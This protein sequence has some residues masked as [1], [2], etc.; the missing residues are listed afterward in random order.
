MEDHCVFCG[1]Y[2]PEGQHVCKRC[3]ER[4][5]DGKIPTF[6]GIG[7]SEIFKASVYGIYYR[8][9]NGIAFDHPSVDIKNK[10]FIIDRKNDKINLDFK[11]YRILWAFEKSE[12]N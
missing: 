5:N 2:V 11:M 6:D 8:Y 4:I 10:I 1:G 9:R 12:L 7:M 3:E